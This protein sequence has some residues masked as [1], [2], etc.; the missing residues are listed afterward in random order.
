MRLL[1]ILAL[2]GTLLA[3]GACTLPPSG[4]ERLNFISRDYGFVD[5][6][7]D[8]SE[9][10]S[11]EVYGWLML[12]EAESAAPP[13]PL[14]RAIGSPAG[15]PRAVGGVC[16]GPRVRR[17]CFRRAPCHERPDATTQQR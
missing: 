14:A 3:A 8:K 4:S 5:R 15:R 12:P 7:R 6:L 13:A 17:S 2:G 10:S 9:G 1:L 16:E 11:R